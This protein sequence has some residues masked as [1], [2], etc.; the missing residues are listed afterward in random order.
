MPVCNQFP[1]YSDQGDTTINENDINDL[2][3][4]RAKNIQNPFFAYYNI[5][6]LRFKFDDLKEIITKSLPDILVFAETKLDSSF[7]NAQFFLEEYYEPTRK[8]M[9][10]HSGGIIEY[11]RKGIVRKRLIDFELEHFESIASELTINKNNFFLLSFYRT[12]RDENKLQNI[13]KFFQE[14]SL[15]LNKVTNKYDNIILMGDINIDL[16]NRK[17]V[18]FKELSEFLD[19]FNLTNLINDKTC[20]FKDHESSLDVILTNKPRR[21]FNSYAFELGI[22]DC[23]KMIVTNLRAHIARLNTK[24]ISYRSMKNFNKENFLNEL[25]QNLDTF[26]CI[27]TNMAYDRLLNILI[28]VLDKHAP[29]K[30]KKVRGNQSRFMNRNLSKAIMKRSYLKSKYLKNKNNINRANYKKQRNLCVKL[31]DEAIKSDFQNTTSTLKSNSKPFYNLIKP[32]MT[33]KGALCSTDINLMENGKLVSKENVLAD[34]FVDYYTNI[35][36]YSSGKN[37]ISIADTLEIGESYDVIIGA[38]LEKYENHPSIISIKSK[39]TYTDRFRFQSVRESDILKMLKSVDSKKSIGIDGLPP[40]IVK[41]SADILAK[42]LTD[43]INQSINEN[44]FPT[45]AKV[46]AVLPLFKKDDRSQKKNY[47]PISVLSTLS[48][49]IGKVLQNQ[50]VSF[51]GNFLSP[52]ISAYRKAHSTQ[53]VLI[54]LIEEWKFGLDNGYF[55]GAVLMD[56]SKAFDCVPHDLL[57]AKLGA[58]G[59]D[60]S[61]LK[62]LYSYLKGRRQCVRINGNLSKYFTI[63]AG[64]PQGSILG[65]ILFNIFIN[66]FYNFFM[67]ANLHGFA[68]DHTLSAKSKSLEVLKDILSSESNIAIKWLDDNDMLA[69]PSKFQVI[70]LTK[71]KEHI[72]LSLQINNKIIESKESVELL[73]I[74]IDDKLKFESHIRELCRKTGGQLNSLYRFKKYLSPLSKKVV[75]TSFIFSNFNYCPLIWNYSSAKSKN[76]IEQVQKRA[77]NFLKYHLDEELLFEPGNSS[78]EVKRLRVLLIEIFKTLNGLN[79]AYMKNIFYRSTNRNSERLKFNIKTQRYNQVKFGKNSLRVLGPILWNSLPNNIKSLQS[80][81]VFKKFIKSWGNFGCPHYNKFVSYYNAIK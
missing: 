68:D 35:V 73:G 78:M 46:A 55:V 64:V 71:T 63:L 51:S 38:I 31:R 54:R 76:K 6:S 34:I 16:H 60:K 62:Y 77:L 9:S 22:S 80:I 1:G 24:I 59:F 10:C 74:E 79:P 69:N 18:G 50:I 29:I 57:I 45:K 17:C 40:Q 23:H 30:R 72:N 3:K 2:N 8:D 12:E 81:I 42:P 25:A 44:I 14:L 33:N 13:A 5:N 11:I 41:Y 75:I 21:F 52:Y 4:L 27:D 26:N 66:D 36:K 19:I 43:I 32:Y 15:I 70:F 58:Y 56:L 47:R 7:S 28:S 53:H 67:V 37:P 61:A 65:P 49:I 39:I 20:F 48:K